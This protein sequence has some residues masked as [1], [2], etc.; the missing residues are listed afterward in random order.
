MGSGTVNG[1]MVMVTGVMVFHKVRRGRSDE[2]G[3][4]TNPTP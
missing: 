4:G 3:Y 2:E 1:L